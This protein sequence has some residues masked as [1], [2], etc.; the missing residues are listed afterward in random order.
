MKY[1]TAQSALLILSHR[2]RSCTVW[3]GQ[4]WTTIF[5]LLAVS[6]VPGTRKGWRPPLLT[7]ALSCIQRISILMQLHALNLYMTCYMYWLN[8][9]EMQQESASWP[10]GKWGKFFPRCVASL[11]GSLQY[12][13]SYAP[14]SCARWDGLTKLIHSNKAALA[15]ADLLLSTTLDEIYPAGFAKVFTSFACLFNCLST[16]SHVH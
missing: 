2:H 15:W 5:R 1:K 11:A 9:N 4:S 3:S 14:V 12:A 13:A 7:H 8:L 10:A 6:L 16:R